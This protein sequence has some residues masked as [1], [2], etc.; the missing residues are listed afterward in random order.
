MGLRLR[1]GYIF[2]SKRKKKSKKEERG[3]RLGHRRNKEFW[4]R[5]SLTGLG[6]VEGYIYLTKPTQN[7]LL[8][9]LSVV[10]DF[11]TK[12]DRHPV[13]TVKTQFLKE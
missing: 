10:V 9:T 7:L 3:D 6:L 8:L 11:C 1:V 5:L 12:K 13:D 2:I 4:A